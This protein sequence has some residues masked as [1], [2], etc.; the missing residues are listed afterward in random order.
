MARAEAVAF[1]AFI[2][3]A[4]TSIALGP[5][6]RASSVMDR[7][8]FGRPLGLP[9]WPAP[10]WSPTSW[11]GCSF[12]VR[13]HGF[14]RRRALP[15]RPKLITPRYRSGT[16]LGPICL[17]P[18]G[19]PVFRSGSRSSAGLPGVRPRRVGACW[20]DRAEPQDARAPNPGPTGADGC[21][22]RGGGGGGIHLDAAAQRLGRQSKPH[23][24][25]TMIKSKPFSTTS[26]HMRHERG[27]IRRTSPWNA[28]DILVTA[29]TAVGCQYREW[30]VS[31]DHLVGANLALSTP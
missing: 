1:G 18:L 29:G 23:P 16:A 17:P 10:K 31:L 27:R 9:R 28:A 20:Q 2:I 14:T 19:P 4:S 22:G 30:P 24:V 26:T 12:A 15:S 11:H 21:V 6:A 5:W 7:S 8:D 13:S 25:E 3:L